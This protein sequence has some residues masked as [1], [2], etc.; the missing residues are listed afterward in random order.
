MINKV[1]KF[2]DFEYSDRNNGLNEEEGIL[3]SLASGFGSVFKGI[4]SGVNFM[5]PAVEPAFKRWLTS[6]I[7][8]KWG[9]LDDSTF[10]F[11][12]QNVVK[13]IPVKDYW[14]I[15]TGD[16]LNAEYLSPLLAEATAQMITEKGIDTIL[17][18]IAKAVGLDPAGFAYKTFVERVQLLMKDREKFKA[19][20]AGIFKFLG[21]I[22]VNFGEFA[23]D[24]DPSTQKKI[25]GDIYSQLAQENPAF[26]KKYKKE[27]EEGGGS[28]GLGGFLSG[29]GKVFSQDK[30]KHD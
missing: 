11:I 28:S 10:S 19:S 18:P 9:I 13:L 4:G 16:K 30:I 7:L 2:D 21:S 14:G 29:L 24:Q 1:K 26:A 17:E 22:E 15:L 12:V 8:E 5:L 27:M 20:L 25:A 3:G 6:K 23:K